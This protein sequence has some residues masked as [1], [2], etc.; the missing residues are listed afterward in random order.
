VEVRVEDLWAE[1]EF[2]GG[3]KLRLMHADIT[4]QDVDAIVNAAN[5]QLQ[6]GGG[7][8]AAI[9]RAGGVE[10]Q[11]QSDAWIEEHGPISEE[12][13]ALTGAGDLP[14]DWVIHVVGPRWGEGEEDRKLAQAVS[15][16]MT[17]AGEQGFQSLALP[18]ISTGIFG[19]PLER[20]ADVILDAIA[21]FLSEDTQGDLR[22]VRIV[23][24][25][26]EGL[27]VFRAAFAARW[28]ESA[29]RE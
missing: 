10:I 3:T 9:S 4:Q 16:A 8:A 2:P 24:I 12:A 1:W 5:E 21:G 19:F 14:S 11:R 27:E 26:E 18:A 17:L 28:P 13:P 29:I 7:V 22:D 20:A 25:D 23:L 6:H 15:G